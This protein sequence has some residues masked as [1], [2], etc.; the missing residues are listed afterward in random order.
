MLLRTNEK[1]GESLRLCRSILAALVLVSFCCNPAKAQDSRPIPISFQLRSEIL[2]R[3]YADYKKSEER[4]ARDIAKICDKNL[5]VWTYRVG[6]DDFPQLS[7][8]LEQV[9]AILTV[10]FELIINENG[11][12]VPLIQETFKPDPARE[13]NMA[14]DEEKI[15]DFLRNQVNS[16]AVRGELLEKLKKRIPLGP[17][18]RPL[19][20]LPLLSPNKP[21]TGVLPLLYLERRYFELARSEF[22]IVC[23]D[24]MNNGIE[25]LCHGLG[26]RESYAATG[27]N[28]FPGILVRLDK[29]NSGK[30]DDVDL[31]Q[32]PKLKISRFLLANYIPNLDEPEDSNL[33]APSPAP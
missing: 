21:P 18:K 20:L 27:M 28:P 6:T 17:A 33:P 26:K 19:T 15:L 16:D 14:E 12:I 13:R 10:R 9:G 30:L 3:M 8:S 5:R 32:L 22:I 23:E 29:Y 2:R 7:C 11:N 24:S 1:H 4:L 25:L 31:T